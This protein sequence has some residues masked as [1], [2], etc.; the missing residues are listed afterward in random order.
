MAGVGLLNRI[1]RKE[2]D[3]IDGPFPQ[4]VFRHRSSKSFID[5]AEKR[6][7]RQA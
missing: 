2:A 3:G 6:R 4:V 1:R 5:A 7:L